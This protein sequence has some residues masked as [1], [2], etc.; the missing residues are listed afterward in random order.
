MRKSIAAILGATAG[1][2]LAGGAVQAQQAGRN[3]TEEQVKSFFDRTQ[4]DVT[5][6][7]KAKNYDR[8]LEWTQNSIADEATF[9]VSNELYQDNKRKS[10][11]VVSLDKDDIMR[12]SSIAAGLMSGMQGQP[13]EDYSL[14]VEIT[15]FTSLGPGVATVTA[16]YIE[17]GTLTVQQAQ[18]AS[19]DQADETLQTSSTQA[20]QQKGESGGT[21]EANAQSLQIEAMAECNHIIRRGEAAD[22]L[23]I[24]LTT[25]Q[26][27]T[28]LQPSEG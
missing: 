13:V 24:G 15:N 23:V 19:A 7:V 9:L 1:L 17:S 28:H 14:H 5:E 16:E 3:L 8:L 10:F 25:C 2:L 18:T 12:L 11:V 21:Q 27:E 6:A 26:A 20:Q 22:Q 4:Q